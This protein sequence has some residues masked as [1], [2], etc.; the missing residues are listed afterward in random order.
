[1]KLTVG[2]Y[3]NQ[4]FVIIYFGLTLCTGK[5]FSLPLNL[6]AKYLSYDLS[7]HRSCCATY[8]NTESIS[9][10]QIGPEFMSFY[11]ILNYGFGAYTGIKTDE[12]NVSLEGN[13]NF[14]K[15]FNNIEPY[16]GFG[17]EV[18]WLLADEIQEERPYSWGGYQ[19]KTTWFNPKI[20]TGVYF[21]R[22]VNVF[23]E[24]TPY[25]NAMGIGY[26]FP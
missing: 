18:F 11:D 23:I 2:K 8:N 16:L 17:V 10:Y 19:K 15:A 22:K 1:M 7:E 13:F 26:I 6:K 12:V 4:I 3:T 24:I 20:N 5:A 21:S 14:L 9:S 25:K